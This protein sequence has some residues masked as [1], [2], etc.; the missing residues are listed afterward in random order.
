M[1]KFTV[2]I[3]AILL[4][5]CS[6]KF[7]YNNADWLVYWYLDDYVELTNEQEDQFD[8]V[9]ASFLDWHRQNEL[10]QYQAHLEDIISDIKTGNITAE[11][12]E[13]HRSRAR[14]HWVR[15]RGYIAQDI[16]DF[17][18][19]MSEDQMVYLFAQLEKENV[20]DEEELLERLEE[21]E[22]DQVKD[23]VKRN[24]KNS[25]RWLGKLNDDQKEFIAGFSD[26]FD[27]T[28][29]HWIEYKR[30]YQQQLRI[31]FSNPDRGDAFKQK[32]FDLI[33]DPERFRSQEFQLAMDA[34]AATSAEYI[35]GLKDMMSNKQMDKLINEIEEVKD[36]LV[37]LQS[38]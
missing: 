36:D 34:N 23:W 12:I 9:F 14:E 35:M 30:E 25:R 16:V 11:R 15:S 38:R 31:V 22:K 7:A 37:S 28:R 32:L 2:L 3:F 20:E 10:P 5:G 21:S 29:Q 4:G 19:T 24:Q 6:T 1:K 13:E 18:T 17:S 27:S 33:V 8:L 26:R